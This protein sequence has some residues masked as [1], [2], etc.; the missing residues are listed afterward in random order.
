[1]GA[2][3]GVDFVFVFVVVAVLKFGVGIYALV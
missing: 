2:A 1:M 3:A